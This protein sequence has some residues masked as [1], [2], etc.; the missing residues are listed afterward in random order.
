MKKLCIIFILTFITSTCIFAVNYNEVNKLVSANNIKDAISLCEQSIETNNEDIIAKRWLSYLYYVNGQYDES[1]KYS[2][3]CI[4]EGKSDTA[5]FANYAG[6]SYMNL[7]NN[8][9]AINY[10]D[11]AIILKKDWSDP[12]NNKG[13]IYLKEGDYLGAKNT[14]LMAYNI[15]VAEKNIK[16][17]NINVYMNYANSLAGLKEYQ[18]AIKILGFAEKLE[19]NN[20]IIHYNTAVVYFE[21]GDY[22]NALNRF[23]KISNLDKEKKDFE[24]TK[25][26]ADSYLKLGKTEDA[27]KYYEIAINIKPDFDIYFNSGILLKKQG[28]FGKAVTYFQKALEQKSD[29]YE[30]L[31]ELGWAEFKSGN[32]D[33]CIEHLKKSIDLKS[34]YLPARI[35]LA[36]IYSHQ[37]DFEN[38]YTQWSHAVLLDPSNSVCKINLANECQNTKKYD[39]AIDL[40]NQVI[41]LDTKYVSAYYGLGTAYL[42]KATLEEKIDV[43]LL[44]KAVEALKIATEKEPT[45]TDAFINLGATYQYLEKYSEAIV[46]Y[47]KAIKISPNNIVAKENLDNIKKIKGN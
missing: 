31:C 34:D 10:F 20:K 35:N 12:Y 11:K 21:K 43:T 42:S 32:V 19:P 7:D 1:I 47:E 28:S 15:Q 17:K 9:E 3:E 25:G 46:A 39:E 29:D 26:V 27:L 4:E 33:I 24:A 6:L 40:Y 5:S 45:N 22:E 41:I 38:A 2:L 44:N 14:L 13:L 36:T 16:K 8:K 30:T 18:E 37:K 23:L